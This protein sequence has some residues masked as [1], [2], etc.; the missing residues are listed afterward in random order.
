MHPGALLPLLRHGDGQSRVH[1]PRIVHGHPGPRVR[2]GRLAEGG[3]A[4]EVHEPVR[5]A[6]DV[7]RRARA[8][9]L[10]LLRPVDAPHR[11][12]GGLAV[13]GGHH[14]PGDRPDEHGGGVDLL[15]HD[16][17]LAGVHTDPRRRLPRPARVHRGPGRPAPGDQDHRPLDRGDAAARGGRRVLHPGLQ[18]HARVLGTARQDGRGH[19][20]GGVDAHRRHRGDG[21]RRVREDHRPHQ[22]HGDPGRREHLPA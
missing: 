5:R 10:R 19:R 11:H 2:P 13:P 9:G 6:D 21:R 22:G 7:H 16:R 20:R 3:G 18:R 1:H 8:R 17:D 14:A 12:H 15:R 4:G